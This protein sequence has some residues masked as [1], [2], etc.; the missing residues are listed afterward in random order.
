MSANYSIKYCKAVYIYITWIDILYSTFMTTALSLKCSSQHLQTDLRYKKRS[1]GCQVS[2][3]SCFSTA[4][5]CS[6]PQMCAFSASRCALRGRA[7]GSF[8]STTWWQ[9]AQASPRLQPNAEVKNK[10]LEKSVP[11]KAISKWENHI[12][13]HWNS[14]VDIL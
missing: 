4:I 7:F 6:R 2:C 1:A 14:N 13:N 9:N 11:I 3:G 8:I 12:E 10:H 5:C